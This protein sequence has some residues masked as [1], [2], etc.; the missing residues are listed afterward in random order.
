MKILKVALL[1]ALLGPLI[2][3]LAFSF[4]A[5]VSHAQLATNWLFLIAGTLKLAVVVYPVATLLG[6][7]PAA[8]TGATFAY[9]I[10][11]NIL[12]LRNYL[13]NSIVCAGLGAMFCGV[14][15]IAL[16]HPPR[17]T[18]AQWFQLLLPYGAFSG[19]VLSLVMTVRRPTFDS[20]GSAAKS[21]AVR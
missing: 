11:R 9:F 8:L 17:D 21:A 5:G 7:I 18:F 15:A 6:L 3:S 2:G 10:Q 4:S 13:V 14:P 19:A 16:H 12:S 1:F 20:P